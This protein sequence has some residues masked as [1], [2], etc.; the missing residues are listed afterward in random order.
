MQKYLMETND[1]LWVNTDDMQTPAISLEELRKQPQEHGTHLFVLQDKSVSFKL[2][3]RDDT[4]LL[5]RAV[6]RRLARSEEVRRN[7]LNYLNLHV[8]HGYRTWIFSAEG[9]VEEGG[10]A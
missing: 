3:H 10:K 6:R 5:L 7:V 1:R 9:C 2:I 4:F 8:V